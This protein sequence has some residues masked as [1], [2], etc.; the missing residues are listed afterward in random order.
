MQTFRKEYQA[1]SQQSGGLSPRIL[2]ETVDAFITSHI[3]LPHSARLMGSPRHPFLVREGDEFLKG[4]TIYNGIYPVAITDLR[5]SIDDSGSLAYRLVPTTG[6]PTSLGSVFAEKAIRKLSVTGAYTYDLA[7]YWALQTLVNEPGLLSVLAK[8]YPFMLIDEAQDVGSMHGALL[9]L[10]QS[11]GTCISAI[12][13]ADQAIFEFADADG[14]W[15]RSFS[16]TDGV[17]V[18]PLSL[19]RRSV[20][21]IVRVANALSRGSSKE[22]RNDPQRTHGAYL[23]TYTKA[24][25]GQAV[26]TFLAII[27][28]NGY[29]LSNTAILCRGRSLVDEIS[30][31]SNEMGQNAT[32]RF[33]HA[34]ACRDGKG[35]IA[36]AFSFVVAGLIALLD[37]PSPDFRADLLSG[38]ASNA[39]AKSVRRIL[40][41]FLRGPA[42][43]LPSAS[44]AAK[45]VWQPTL[46]S[47]IPRL[48][49]EIEDAGAGLRAA[50][51]KQRMTR[52]KLG[53]SSL[54]QCESDVLV[55]GCSIRTVHQAKGESID[56]VLYVTRTADITNLLQGTGTE[57][58][59]I[60]YVAVTRARDLLVLA[61]PQ[62]IGPMR[63]NRLVAFG[64]KPWN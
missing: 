31:K 35:D 29:D 57:A 22:I 12:G 48:L 28:A 32:A 7:R 20:A 63:M 39:V 25:V 62:S 47:R 64:F 38:S 17:L 61:V 1:L 13:D 60:G 4:H 58:G 10:L 51:W 14:T 23:L 44:L 54:L 43:G 2:I 24:N 3:V 9:S 53:D 18:H 19:N 27:Q 6:T 26:T 30:G 36:D 59:R 52:A 11:K 46:K 33:A 5:V 50:N 42:T 45:G 40:W 16:K 41:Q 8:R 37:N 49:Q 34:A 15:L 21:S 55:A 56:A